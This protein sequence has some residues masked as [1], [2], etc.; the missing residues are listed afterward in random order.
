MC[1]ELFV[2]RRGLIHENYIF[3]YIL[4]EFGSSYVGA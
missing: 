2:F 1:R 4:E 3:I